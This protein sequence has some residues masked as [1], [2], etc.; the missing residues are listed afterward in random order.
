MLVLVKCRSSTVRFFGPWF[1][2][3]PPRED[4]V[5]IL[6][7][8]ISEYCAIERID[9]IVRSADQRCE[10]ELVGLRVRELRRREILLEVV[11]WI[12]AVGDSVNT[13]SQ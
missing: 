4:A 7:K 9:G 8:L 12:I 5:Q 6:Q 10:T 13:N 11:N 2:A 1:A 3:N